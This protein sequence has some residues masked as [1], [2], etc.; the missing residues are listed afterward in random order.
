[1]D[2][3]PKPLREGQVVSP[4]TPRGKAP[5]RPLDFTSSVRQLRPFT[6]RF[7]FFT[8]APAYLWGRFSDAVLLDFLQTYPSAQFFYKKFDRQIFR[9]LTAPN[10]DRDWNYVL[11]AVETP[12][13][14]PLANHLDGAVMS[15]RFQ[16]A[17]YGFGIQELTIADPLFLDR[18]TLCPA[19]VPTLLIYAVGVHSSRYLAAFVCGSHPVMDL[20]ELQF[21]KPDS[22]DKLYA[23]A[24][25]RYG[26][27]ARAEV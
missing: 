10:G 4:G 7:T 1:M 9:G 17:T 6:E 14:E 11:W 18:V 21:Y 19:D 16:S 20:P 3:F 27:L 26:P 15:D 22:H 24:L 12:Y 13:W 25:F 23:Q 5:K 8:I 2:G